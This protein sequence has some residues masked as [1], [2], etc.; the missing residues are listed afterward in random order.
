MASWRSLGDLERSPAYQQWLEREFPEGASELTEEQQKVSRRDFTKLMGASSA[1][2]GL[3][4]VACRPVGQ[5]VPYKKAP[6]WVIPGKP[7]FYAS[8]MPLA[9]GAV[10]L[11]VTTYEGR[12]TKV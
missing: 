5:I 1:L 3:S 9:T 7:L 12:P 8:A 11:V 2:A 4:L 10:P 6:E